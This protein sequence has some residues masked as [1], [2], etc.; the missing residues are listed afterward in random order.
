MLT[1]LAV[2]LPLAALFVRPSGR[3]SVLVAVRT[4]KDDPPPKEES[5]AEQAES[6]EQ[7]MQRMQ[8]VLQPEIR[9]LRGRHAG[10]RR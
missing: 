2:L 4:L 3:E 5:A 10:V 6:L 1:L 7:R 9:G 8:R